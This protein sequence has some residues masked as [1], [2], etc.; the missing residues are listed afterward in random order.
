[1]SAFVEA[2]VRHVYGAALAATADP[3][4][5]EDVTHAVMTD[6]AAGRGRADARSLVASAVLRSMHAAPHPAFAPMQIEER[7]V[8]ALA[9]LGGYSVHEIAEA[10]GIAPVE[11]RARMTRGLRALAAEVS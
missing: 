4:A 7:E 1:M 11:A 8:V 3:E 9:R 5:A 2:S 6:A 10:L